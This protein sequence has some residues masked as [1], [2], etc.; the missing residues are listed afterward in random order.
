MFILW[1]TRLMNQRKLK[2]CVLVNGTAMPAIYSSASDCLIQVYIM[3]VCSAQHM[4]THFPILFA[5]KLH[6][7]WAVAF[8]TAWNFDH[9]KTGSKAWVSRKIIINECLSGQS[10]FFFLDQ[11]IALNPVNDYYGQHGHILIRPLAYFDISLL[12]LLKP[13]TTCCLCFNFTL[14]QIGVYSKA[15]SR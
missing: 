13:L 2:A 1:Q 9:V 3:S 7:E 8:D 12:H 4:T 6:S 11:L 10:F 14:H 15:I 5:S